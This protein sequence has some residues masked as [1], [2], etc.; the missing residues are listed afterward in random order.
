MEV[1]Q[2]FRDLLA[3]FNK[4]KVDYIIVGAYAL[5]FHGA[6]RYTGDLDVFVR[7]DPVNA[8][9]IIEALHEFGFGSVDLTAADF[10]QEGK[11]VQLGF[12]PVSV[13]IIT[14]I[15]GVSWEQARSGRVDGWFGDLT[16]YYI[17]RDEFISNKRALG[18]KKDMADLE[19]IGED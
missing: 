18:R 9:G 15:T 5:G 8:R 12:P 1:Q 2:D 6:P 16:V 10:E 4:H 14:S 11:I 7:P 17:G 3:L 19:A 13:D